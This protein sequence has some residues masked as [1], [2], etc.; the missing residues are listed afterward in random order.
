MSREKEVVDI[1]LA[2]F[3]EQEIYETH[4]KNVG[5][6]FE[7]KGLSQGRAEIV[8]SAFRNGKT[9]EQIAMFNDIPLNEVQ[10]IINSNK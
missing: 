9:P 3:D 8:M 4:F 1:M 7:E 6:R 10:Q 5:K 2:L